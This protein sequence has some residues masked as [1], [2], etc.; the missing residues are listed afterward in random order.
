MADRTTFTD[1]EWKAL[2]EVPLRIT[3]ALVAV[4]PHGPISMVKE[5]AASAREVAHLSERGPADALI[6][7]L[8]KEAGSREARHDVEAHRGQTPDQIVDTALAEL[9]PAARALDKLTPD[10]GAE[11]RAWFLDIAKAVAGAAKSISPDEQ[12]VLDRITTQFGAAAA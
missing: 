9:A 6:A 5:A 4:G 7:E 2:T 10:E 1:D 3:L 11:V 8:A 12:A